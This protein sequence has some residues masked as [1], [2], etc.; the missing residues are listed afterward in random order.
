MGRDA[1]QLRLLSVFHYVVGGMM[2]LVNISGGSYK[3]VSTYTLGR[4]TFSIGQVYVNIRES[5]I[6]M[7][8][9]ID[10]ITGHLGYRFDCA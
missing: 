4:K 2:A 10:E 1:D 9:R 3:D 8:A 6:Q 5:I 7:K